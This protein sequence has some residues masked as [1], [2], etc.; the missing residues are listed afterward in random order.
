MYTKCENG[1]SR[2]PKLVTLARTGRPMTR[3]S[4][5]FAGKIAS[6]GKHRAAGKSQDSR[7]LDPVILGTP[8]QKRRKNAQRSVA[9]AVAAWPRGGATREVSLL[10][11]RDKAVELAQAVQCPRV[12]VRNRFQPPAQTEKQARIEVDYP[13]R[14][15]SR[16][17]TG[18]DRGA[19]GR[20]TRESA[21]ILGERSEGARNLEDFANG[22][23]KNSI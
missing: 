6:L 19:R 20:R 2:E 10:W 1:S 3:K 8:P 14:A 7:F 15:Q 17:Q 13:R 4:R 9:R 22:S 23:Q 11:N 16:A 5:W 21:G 12:R 18:P